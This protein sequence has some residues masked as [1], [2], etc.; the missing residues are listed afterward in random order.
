MSEL[1]RETKELLARGREG[2]PLGAS[3]RARLKRTVLA[4]VAAATVVVSSTQAAAWTSLA[5][6]ALAALGIVATLGAAGAVGVRAWQGS[7]SSLRPTR[8]VVVAPPPPIA[9][10]PFPPPAEV[11]GLD[12]GP[13]TNDT[14]AAA[15]AAT[16]PQAPASLG[17]PLPTM[18]TMPAMPERTPSPPASPRTEMHASALPETLAPT[19]PTTIPAA[20]A[21]ASDSVPVSPAVSPGQSALEQEAALLRQADAFLK[22]G[23]AANALRL[24]DDLAARFPHGSLEPERSAERVFALCRAGRVDDARREAGMFLE[25]HGIGPLATRVRASCGGSR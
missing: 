13:V 15:F 6:K 8:A 10:T 21:V 24:L 23:D 17:A 19:F 14:S 7:R 5:S 20:P 4:Q 2:E 3:H 11:Q 25:A 1:S 16:V 22:G 12:T 9:R 18:A